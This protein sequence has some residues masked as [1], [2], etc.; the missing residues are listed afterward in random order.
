MR[1]KCVANIIS[2]MGLTWLDCVQCI[3]D[4]MALNSDPIPLALCI[5]LICS[6]E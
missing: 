6:L 4:D 1:C 3:A 2:I 5:M